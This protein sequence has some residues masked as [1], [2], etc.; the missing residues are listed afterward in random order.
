MTIDI[1]AFCTR[2][3][4]DP[5]YVVTT[6]RGIRLRDVPNAEA[7]RII[8][9][10]LQS[11]LITSHEDDVLDAEEPDDDGITWVE[12]EEDLVRPGGPADQWAKRNRAERRAD[13]AKKRTR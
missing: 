12:N 5:A 4:V 9:A 6:E 1:P 11:G 8:V 13:A 7:D 10:L 3:D 2:F